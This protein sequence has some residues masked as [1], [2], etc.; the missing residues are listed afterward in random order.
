MKRA[1]HSIARN[2]RARRTLLLCV[3]ALAVFAS[4]CAKRP[5]IAKRPPSTTTTSR[6]PSTS[7]PPATAS[8]SRPSPEPAK[9]LPAGVFE[10]GIASWYGIPYHGRRAA[11]GEIYDM[12]KMTAAHREEEVDALAD[13]LG[14]ALRG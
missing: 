9:P 4:G 14:E 5:V 10:Q 7:Q 12:H 3:A 6:G 13:A 1:I 8:P 2:A 11:N